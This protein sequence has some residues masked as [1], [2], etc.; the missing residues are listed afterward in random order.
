MVQGSLI[1]GHSNL[2]QAYSVRIQYFS[3]TAKSVAK[4]ILNRI[5]DPTHPC[6][7]IE[8]VSHEVISI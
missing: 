6:H 3:I 2:D 1:Y 5:P 4:H 8:Y 7:D